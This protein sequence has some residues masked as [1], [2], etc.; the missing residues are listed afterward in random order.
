MQVLESEYFMLWIVAQ[1]K[2]QEH[3]LLIIK[4]DNLQRK[5]PMTHT[6]IRKIYNSRIFSAAARPA[7]SLNV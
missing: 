3:A 1:Y 7:P 5:L 2:N 6:I 4:G